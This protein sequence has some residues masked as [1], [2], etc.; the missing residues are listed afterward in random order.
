[1]IPKGVI[2][3][4]HREGFRQIK[5][6]SLYKWKIYCGTSMSLNLLWK[7]RLCLLEEITKYKEN[8]SFA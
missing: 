7:N 8:K 4:T 1:M 6:C 5:R 3:S 2:I